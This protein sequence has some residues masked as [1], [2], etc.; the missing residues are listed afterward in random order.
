M[1][2]GTAAIPLRASAQARPTIRVGV[3]SGAETFSEPLYGVESG[4]FTRAGLDVQ[5]GIF[6]AAGAIAAALAGGALD[7]GSVD[8][9]VLANAVNRGVPLIA[10]AGSGLFRAKEPTSGLCIPIKSSL[11]SA[12]SL[13]GQTIAVGTLVSLTSISLRM[14]LARNGA[15]PAQVQFVEMRFSEMP[16][17]LQR[18][19]VTA[20]YITEPLLTQH[21]DELKLIAI[22]YSEIAKTFPISVIAA[23]RSWLAQNS[24]TA[25]RFVAA[26][27]E[28]GRW[29]NGNRQ[30][31]AVMLA[32]YTKLDL[33]II[34]RMHRTSFATSLDPSMMQPILDAAA[35]YK[36]IDRP[37]NAADLMIQV[38][39]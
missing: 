8:V 25:R 28:T 5:P 37:T 4:I 33:D 23:G 38:M 12:K 29:L 20:A 27:Y 32:K 14:W 22:P 11:R 9:I 19:T 16:A 7:L 3:E 13:E 17:A 24:D 35:T 15:N 21:A 39:N 26:T 30:Q 10:I 18:G 31:S 2:A 6:P 36:L 1:T 34:R